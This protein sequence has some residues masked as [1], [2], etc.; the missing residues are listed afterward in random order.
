MNDIS[1]Y[2]LRNSYSVAK[3]LGFVLLISFI[4][5]KPIMIS[6]L[7]STNEDMELCENSEEENTEEE[8][9]FE[10][11]FLEEL[12]YNKYIHVE[13]YA[14]QTNCLYSFYKASHFSN[15][16]IEINSPP[17]ETC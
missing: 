10:D 2:N 9:E 17:P 13:N 1:I 11:D 12:S 3:L 7:E 15:F 16:I 8:V 6:I 5:F 14:H 4:V